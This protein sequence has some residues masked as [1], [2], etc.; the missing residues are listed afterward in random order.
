MGVRL[1]AQSQSKCRW[2]R[3]E[4]GEKPTPRAHG[5]CRVGGGPRRCPGCRPVGSPPW[6]V[7]VSAVGAGASQVRGGQGVSA[8]VLP[9]R[10]R[11]LTLTLRSCP[12]W[13]RLGS[14][15]PGWLDQVGVWPLGQNRFPSHLVAMRADAMGG[16][17]GAIGK[18]ISR[19]SFRLQ[20]PLGL[21]QGK[22]GFLFKGIRGS[23]KSAA[24][25][26]ISCV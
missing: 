6:G 10:Y 16:S 20:G 26:L 22:T 2:T 14:W 13:Q 17:R 21:S 23:A 24:L 7:L 19:R 3:R 12:I 18:Y 1:R 9:K 11:S 8:G 4:E 25:V 15:A 5:R